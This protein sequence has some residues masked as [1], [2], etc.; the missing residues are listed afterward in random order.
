MPPMT[1]GSAV[2]YAFCAYM[3]PG[4]IQEALVKRSIYALAATFSIGAMAFTLTALKPTNEALHERVKEVVRQ[5]QSGEIIEVDDK[6]EQTERRIRQ[7]G[8]MNAIRAALPVCAVVSA[9]TALTI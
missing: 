8:Q 3:V 4:A 2:C 5:E 9:M 7:W 1:I 6:R